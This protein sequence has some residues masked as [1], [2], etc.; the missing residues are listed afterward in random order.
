MA[1]GSTLP[2]TSVIPLAPRS[3]CSL[4]FTVVSTSTDPR[5]RRWAD[6]LHNNHGWHLH[7]AG[8]LDSALSAFE[9]ALTAY[10]QTC[11]SMQV[12][13][14]QWSNAPCLRSLHRNEEALA[15]QRQ[16]QRDDEPDSFV[17][18]EIFILERELGT[19]AA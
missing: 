16:L 18:E 4:A 17:D 1:P 8:E 10:E 9:S 14:A 3:V 13:I 12:H 7:E 11:S 19:S 6:A 15:I 2:G 5:V